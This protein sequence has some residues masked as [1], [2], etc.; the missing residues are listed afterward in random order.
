M[1][2]LGNDNLQ[3][4]SNQ[5]NAPQNGGNENESDVEELEIDL[6]NEE[7]IKIIEDQFLQMVN[8]DERF[9]TN[10]GDEIF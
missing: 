6:E 9:R 8:S 2:N 7:D 1:N 4:Q 3:H 5:G 10:F